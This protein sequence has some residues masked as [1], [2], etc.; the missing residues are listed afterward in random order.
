[1]NLTLEQKRKLK[2]AKTLILLG[3]FLSPVYALFADG[4]KSITPYANALV[5]A[6]LLSLVI[7]FFEFILF[8]G[9]A[10]KIKF[11]QLLFLR[12][13]LYTGSV[14]SVVTLTMIVSRMFRY[15]LNFQEVL[16]SNEFKNYIY[17]QD[18]LTGIFYTLALVG[19]VVFTLQMQRKIGPKVLLAL[20]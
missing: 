4:F 14:F 13:A 9:K 8:T 15:N 17:E 19:L 6:I 1:M 10:K 7:S 5:I 16:N 11:Y 18:Y 20:I 3:L 12:I 2:N